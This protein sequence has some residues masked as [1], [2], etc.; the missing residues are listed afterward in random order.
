[1][2]ESASW[3]QAVIPVVWVVKGLLGFLW[4]IVLQVLGVFQGVSKSVEV[5]WLIHVLILCFGL[6][7]RSIVILWVVHS[8]EISVLSPGDKWVLFHWIQVI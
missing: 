4:Q 5:Q 7:I 1:M 3:G 8:L 2:L 6:P